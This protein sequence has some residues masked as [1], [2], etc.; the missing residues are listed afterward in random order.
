MENFFFF[1][2]KD[3]RQ[4]IEMEKQMDQVKNKERYKYTD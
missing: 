3:S 2:E 1:N 4:R